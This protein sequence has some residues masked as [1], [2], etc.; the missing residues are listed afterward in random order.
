MK[1]ALHP[2]PSLRLPRLARVSLTA[3]LLLL[4]QA[5]TRA[6]TELSDSELTTVFST[7][8]NGYQREKLPDGSLK[9]VRY[10]F[11]EGTFDPGSARDSSLDRV[12]FAQLAKLLA[13]AL[14]KQGYLPG[15]DKNTI[16][17]VIV[18]HWGRTAGWQSDG[19]GDA[20]GTLK[21]TYATMRNAF[22]DLPD[23]A[24]LTD[25]QIKALVSDARTR[26]PGG[27]PGAANEMDNMLLML[28]MQ[29]DARDR[30]NTR[31]A[32][33]LGYQSTLSRLPTFHGN[34]VSPDRDDL[35]QEIE[36]D[37]YYVILAAYDFQAGLK[38][39]QPKIL[40]IT[41][42]SLETHGNNF[43]G[44]I[45]QMIQAASAHFGHPSDRLRHA[46]PSEGRAVP[47]KLEVI[48]YQE[49]KK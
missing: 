46:R 24:T 22:P 47:G 42:F 36:D 13:P 16:D 27:T 6:A 5:L 29:A 40:W 30:T 11:G 23:P 4:G 25:E 34:L 12:K 35:V 8:H 10:V 14:A 2:S 17:Q 21:T 48:D 37:R 18:V 49:P 15:R 7:V 31:N 38:S 39:R 32:K 45:S 43:D 26:G 19:Y 20:Y 9:P 33:L 44:S 1:T 41:R 28:E 3:S